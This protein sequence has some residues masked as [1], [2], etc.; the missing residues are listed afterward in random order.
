MGNDRLSGASRRWGMVGARCLF[1][2]TRI[3]H[4][5]RSGAL[6]SHRTAQNRML[7]LPHSIQ[8]FF[9]TWDIIY[10]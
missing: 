1:V 6:A 9:S 8:A 10:T 4:A 2:W 7:G 3:L 5:P